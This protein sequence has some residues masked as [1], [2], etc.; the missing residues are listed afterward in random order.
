VIS[1]FDKLKRSLSK[2]KDNLLGKLSRVVGQRKVDEE[3]LEEIEEILIQADVG[4]KATM[5]LVESL[6]KSAREQKVSDETSVMALLQSEITTILSSQQPSSLPNGAKP[7]EVWLITGVNGVGKT[8][9]IG[10]LATRCSGD[11]KKVM[12]G[13]VIHS[14]LRQLIRLLSGRSAAEWT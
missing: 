7:P 2:T 13:A 10:K 14:V 1:A 3:L 12:I 5:R 6:R 11:G 8:T 9:T 4:V